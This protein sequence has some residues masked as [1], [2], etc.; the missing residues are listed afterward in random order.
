MQKK[1]NPIQKRL[2]SLLLVI[3]LLA[4]ATIIV[5]HV[6]GYG[7]DTSANGGNPVE[8]TIPAPTE[9]EM[10][11]LGLEGKTLV[12]R[13]SMS[14]DVVDGTQH[15]QGIVLSSALQTSK[16]MGYNG[17]TPVFVYLDSDNKIH[18]VT[19]GANDE[20]P[21]FYRRAAGGI[22]DKWNGLS[23]T[24]AIAQEV[25]VVSGATYTSQ[26]LIDN[27]RTVLSVYEKT[28]QSRY[29]EPPIGWP[30]TIA[31]FVFFA[32]IALIV[33]RNQKGENL[34]NIPETTNPILQRL[35]SLLLVFLLLASTTITT[36]R[37]LGHDW[38]NTVA[39]DEGTQ[40]AQTITVP[41]EEEMTALGLEDKTL[42]ARDS[43]SWTVVDK[44]QKKQ[45]IVLS[46]ALQTD[47]FMGYNGST[48]IFIYLDTNNKIQSVVGGA[49]DET[50][51]FYHRASGGI[52]DKW[53]GLSVKEAIAQEVDVVSGATYTSQSLIDNLRAVLSVYSETDLSRHYEPVIGWVRTIALFIVFAF[54][55]L[56]AYRYKKIRWMRTLVLILNTAVT[57]FWC[58]QFLSF[59]IL[60]GMVQN[61]TSLL[62]YLPTV[63]MLLLALIMP[64]VHKKNY[65]CLWVCPYG[66][67]QELAWKLPLPKVKIGAKA[68]KVMHKIRMSI[69]A[70]LIILLWLGVGMTVLDYEPFSAFIVV[71]AAPAVMILAGAFIVLGIFIPHP[72]C[73]C[74]CPVGAVLNLAE[75]T[76][77]KKAKPSNRR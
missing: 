30:C 1:T 57:G 24:E 13:D 76:S 59:S 40:V 4:S 9:E 72:W 38:S 34:F 54:G 31:L 75:K 14:W 33:Y 69:L 73:Q 64:Y 15:K 71:T 17:S 61:G 67:L 60:R 42:I 62:L 29:Y 46:S 58:G 3:L 74:F 63:V 50:P 52:L 12:A 55:L 49:N 66:S 36:G 56:V 47:K 68:F 2:F 44:A 18:S 37:L 21:G 22:L 25:D 27:L 23:V 43:M 70:I 11:A 19:G 53:N 6:L 7:E 35:F 65:Y 32:V 5:G 39:A 26:S 16:F 48:P 10:T 41:T 45:G 20:T 28:N 51:S 8:Q 77:K